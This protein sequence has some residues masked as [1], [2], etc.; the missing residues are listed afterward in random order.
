MLYNGLLLSHN[1]EWN[2]AICKNMD[3]STEYYAQWNK[4]DR[5]RE[6]WMP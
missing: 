2:S 3:G 6:I 5:E 1:K 4:S